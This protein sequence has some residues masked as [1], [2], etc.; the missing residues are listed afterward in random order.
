MSGNDFDLP[1]AWQDGVIELPDEALPALEE[2]S[3]DLR[4]LAEII[5]VRLALRVAQVFS[6]TPIRVYGVRKWIIRHRDRCMR[7]EYDQG[8]I[9]GVDLGR[10]YKVGERQTWY[11]LGSA[12]PDERQIRMF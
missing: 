8:G 6:G 12:E 1:T 2:L 9:S 4:L 11:I 10:K 5:G 3:G 7:R